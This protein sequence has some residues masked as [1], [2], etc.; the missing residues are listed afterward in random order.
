M[1]AG[2]G[3]GLL[4]LAALVAGSIAAQGRAEALNDHI[5]DQCV[6]DEVQDASAYTVARITRAQLIAT[7]RRVL[8]TITA[9]SPERAYQLRALSEGIADLTDQ[10]VALE[11]PDEHECDPPAGV[12]P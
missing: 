10:M 1:V 2:L 8:A 12:G 5:Y 3:L 11:P 4:I 9:G 7:R 6:R